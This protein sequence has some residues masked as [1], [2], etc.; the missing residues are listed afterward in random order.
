[1]EE[2]EYRS[3][4]NTGA[5][6]EIRNAIENLNREVQ[7]LESLAESLGI[8]IENVSKEADPE[9]NKIRMEYFN[10]KGLT[11]EFF[12]VKCVGEL[13]SI[14]DGNFTEKTITFGMSSQHPTPK[15]KTALKQLFLRMGF[16]VGQWDGHYSID[17]LTGKPIK[18]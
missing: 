9:G 5:V 8:L 2:E 7:A 10:L 4:K 14:A 3:K 1:M 11:S 18:N 12:Q 6:I 15:Q 13:N 17:V 16:N